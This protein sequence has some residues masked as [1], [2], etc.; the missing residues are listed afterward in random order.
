MFVTRSETRVVE[1]FPG[2]TRRTLAAGERLMIVESVMQPGASMPLHY[3]P[4]E[5]VSYVT[6]SSRLPAMSTWT[7]RVRVLRS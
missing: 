4:H 3:H 1:M 5:Q 2:V 7:R 6:E